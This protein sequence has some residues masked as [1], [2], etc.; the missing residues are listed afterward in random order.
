MPTRTKQRLPE[1]SEKS[2]QTMVCELARL[3][4]WLVYHTYD[5]RRSQRGFPDLVLVR[6]RRLVFME[7][8]RESG[9]PTLDQVVWLRDLRATGAEC[10]LVRPSDWCLVERVLA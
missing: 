6:G 4:G 9:N 8:K 10:Y 7:C 2:F 1:Q 5:S 3:A